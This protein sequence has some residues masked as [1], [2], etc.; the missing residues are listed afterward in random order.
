MCNEFKFKAQHSVYTFKVVS[1]WMYTLCIIISDEEPK[2]TKENAPQ[3]VTKVKQEEHT[4][5]VA[6]KVNG[7]FSVLSLFEESKMHVL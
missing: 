1:V 7:F 2:T 3:V 4:V 5:T 6:N